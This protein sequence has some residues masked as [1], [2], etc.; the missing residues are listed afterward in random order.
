MG[1]LASPISSA[2]AQNKA[3]KS[4]QGEFLGAADQG[5]AWV[6]LTL[7]MLGMGFL[8]RESIFHM[9]DQLVGWKRV[10][11][12]PRGRPERP[13]YSFGRLASQTFRTL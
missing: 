6:G 12:N 5:A 9:G 10:K 1:T 2:S 4:A 8:Q 13:E 11:P 3:R 7:G